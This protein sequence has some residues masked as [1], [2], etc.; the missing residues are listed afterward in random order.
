MQ[1]APA[2]PHSRTPAARE[3]SHTWRPQHWMLRPPDS[4]GGGS[5]GGTTGPHNTP[6][7]G[8]PHG[9]TRGASPNV[10][11][12]SPGTTGRECVPWSPETA[13][14]PV[15]QRPQPPPARSPQLL[16]HLLPQEDSSRVR[17]PKGALHEGAA[18]LPP[19]SGASAQSTPGREQSSGARMPNSTQIP[20]ERSRSGQGHSPH[21][22]LR[23]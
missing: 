2:I 23:P 18:A 12:A 1:G 15:P 19:A 8:R 3:A 14:V 6:Q 9:V 21:A 17:R 20:L 5:W 4:M 13:S 10:A 7:Q 16:D 22:N 11:H